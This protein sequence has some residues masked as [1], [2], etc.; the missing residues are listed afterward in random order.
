MIRPAT[1]TDAPQLQEIHDR[2]LLDIT[3]VNDPEYAAK[4]QEEGFTVDVKDDSLHNRIQSSH[5]LRIATEGTAIL[6]YIDI[7]PEVY[8]PEEANDIIWFD[9]DLKR[10]YYHDKRAIALNHIA[11]TQKG[12]GIASKLLEDTLTTLKGQGY[13]HLFAIVTTAPVTNCASIIWHTRNNFSRACITPPD[14]L[15]ELK[16]YQSVLFH[17]PI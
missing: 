17:R 12:T 7:N 9:D 1:P 2:Y 14:D 16:H 8:F 15:F 11:V 10:T 6:G 13:E 4:T 3:R 5:L